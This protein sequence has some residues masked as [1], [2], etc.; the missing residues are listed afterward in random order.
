MM[1]Q[2]FG[3]PMP[4]VQSIAILP[5]LSPPDLPPGS[6]RISAYEEDQA[7]KKDIRRH[8]FLPYR[9]LALAV[10]AVLRARQLGIPR[11]WFGFHH[12]LTRDNCPD[13][14]PEFVSALNQTLALSVLGEDAVE[15]VAPLHSLTKEQVVR[16]GRSLNVPIELTYSCYEA[17]QC[18]SCPNCY[19]RREAL[20][21][22]S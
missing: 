7:K 19:H 21:A 3:L 9:N 4:E 10:P 2:H 20:I 1:S 22:A 16:L 5:D 13:A 18:D 17:R 11:V 14:T 6:P 15:V 8:N 12:G